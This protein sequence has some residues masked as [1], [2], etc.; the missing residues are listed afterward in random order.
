MRY[1]F[2]K[3]T[4]VRQRNEYEENPCAYVTFFDSPCLLE[5]CYLD[6]QER[7]M[8][9]TWSFMKKGAQKTRSMMSPM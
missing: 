6:T 7:S 3:E 5:S 1:L 4:L 2:W 8:S 9:L